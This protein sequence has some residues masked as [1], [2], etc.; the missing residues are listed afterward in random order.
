NRR[1]VGRLDNLKAAAALRIGNRFLDRGAVTVPAFVHCRHL[2]TTKKAV[3]AHQTVALSRRSAV[4]IPRRFS[5]FSSRSAILPMLTSRSVTASLTSRIS[6]PR[7]FVGSG[8]DQ[9]IA[10]IIHA[11]DKR[12]VLLF[13]LLGL[14]GACLFHHPHQPH[15]TDQLSASSTPSG[16]RIPCKTFR[17]LS[18]A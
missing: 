1:P 13:R 14:I 9:R 8:L 4:S 12:D 6:A 17:P 11:L 16:R 10:G 15:A 3:K 5:I 2:H 7:F 18:G